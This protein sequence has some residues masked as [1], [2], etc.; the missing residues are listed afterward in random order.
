MRIAGQILSIGS[1]L[2]GVA[3]LLLLLM[4]DATGSE[5]TWLAVAL[6]LNGL[7]RLWLRRGR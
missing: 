6:S 5:S 4:Q 7:V 2:A 3:L 1:L